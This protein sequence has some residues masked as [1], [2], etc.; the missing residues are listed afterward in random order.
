M[1]TG[2]RNIA[3][4]I[5]FQCSNQIW[6]ELSKSCKL[7]FYAESCK[8]VD[9]YCI[10]WQ[11]ISGSHTSWQFWRTKF[12][13]RSFRVTCVTKSQNMSTAEL[14]VCQS[15]SCWSSRSPWQTFPNRR[16]F[17]FSSPSVWNSLPH[18]VLISD[19]LSVFKSRRKTFLFARAF[20]EQHW[21]DLSLQRLWSND[22]V[23]LLLSLS[24]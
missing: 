2:F 22:H 8:Y 3:F 20:T 18:T 17:R 1:L 5:N 9:E 11:F 4:N 24:L 21:S 19:S 23:E 16:D 10:G 12:W 15:S 7:P 14:H 6:T 13:A